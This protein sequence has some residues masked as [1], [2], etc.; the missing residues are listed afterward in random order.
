MKSFIWMN[1]SVQDEDTIYAEEKFLN[2]GK[3]HFLNA[4]NAVFECRYSL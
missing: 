2:A 4:G 3:R 1:S